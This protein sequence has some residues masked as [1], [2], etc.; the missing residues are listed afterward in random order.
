MKM[1]GNGVVGV[2]GIVLAAG[3]GWIT[4]PEKSKLVEQLIPDNGPTIVGRAVS[5][6]QRVRINPLLVINDKF[7]QQIRQVVIGV[8][9]DPRD[10]IIQEQ[11]A[12]TAQAVKLCFPY[13]GRHEGNHL[14]VLYGDMPLWHHQT[15]KSLLMNHLMAGNNPVISMFSITISRGCPQAVKQFGRILRNERGH[16]IGVKE[17]YEM[18]PE[19][20]E[21]AR[22]V[23]PSAWVFNRSWIE[24]N[25]SC[26]PF[27]EKGD[28]FAPE[29]WL[30]DLVL[31]AHQQGRVVNEVPL[32]EVWQAV[33]VNT[34]RELAIAQ[35]FYRQYWAYLDGV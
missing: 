26:L 23:N 6:F 25:I 9:I 33:G 19:E 17:P 22:T 15:I 29:Q 35:D 16:I 20:I 1:N 30:P 5:L 21:G 3:Y 4:S 34:R 31:L 18:S 32:T 14:L 11:R 10:F 13:I 7:S 12:G 24:E 27:H 2:V 28:G 8:G